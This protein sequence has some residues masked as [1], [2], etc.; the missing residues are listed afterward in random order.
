MYMT[1]MHVYYLPLCCQH[2]LW[3]FMVYNNQYESY[4]MDYNYISHVIYLSLLITSHGC[5][6]F[7]DVRRQHF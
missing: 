1:E 2:V 3:M 4:I 5:H 7:K 6:M